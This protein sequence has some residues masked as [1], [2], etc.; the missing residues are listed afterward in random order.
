MTT[1]AS[2]SD[3][4]NTLRWSRE[5]RMA[6]NPDA[7]GEG[8][9]CLSCHTACRSWVVPAE[10]AQQAVLHPEPTVAR[11]VPS[12]ARAWSW[13]GREGRGGVHPHTYFLKNMS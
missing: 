8:W 10:E 2:V 5:L 12:T 3:G 1:N 6:Y 13:L 7:E 11:L 4:L 9:V